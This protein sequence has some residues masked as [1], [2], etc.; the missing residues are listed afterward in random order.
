[1]SEPSIQFRGVEESMPM[2]SFPGAVET[3]NAGG[4]SSGTVGITPTR[5]EALFTREQLG[6]ATRRIRVLRRLR[7]LVL[8]VGGEDVRVLLIDGEERVEYWLPAVPLRK[9]RITEQHQPFE[10][11]EFET[12]EEDGSYA[13]GYRYRPLAEADA[14]F[15]DVLD[16]DAEHRRRRDVIL[17]KLGNAEA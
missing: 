2:L 10:M 6:R 15:S 17:Q 8:E 7:G 3:W 1:M 9:A 4:I 14:V 13:T 12:T 11:D 16:I 5:T